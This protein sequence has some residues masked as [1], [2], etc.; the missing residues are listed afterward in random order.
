MEVAD[1]SANR[2]KKVRL[3]L[4]REQ[5]VWGCPEPGSHVQEHPGLGQRQQILQLEGSSP[6]LSSVTSRDLIPYFWMNKM[7]QFSCLQVK[8]TRY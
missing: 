7:L 4:F 1:L 2:T 3:I 8:M 5:G 6:L